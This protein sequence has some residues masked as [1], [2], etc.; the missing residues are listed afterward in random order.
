[1]SINRSLNFLRLSFVLSTILYTSLLAAQVPAGFAQKHASEAVIEDINILER[2]LYQIHG[3]IFTYH[4]QAAFKD[5]FGGLRA[6][7]TEAMTTLE[8]YKVIG[9]LSTLIGDSHTE[10]NLPEAYQDYVDSEMLLFPFGVRYLGEKLYLTVNLSGSNAFIPGAEILS[11]NGRDALEIFKVL[12]QYFERDGFN[13]SGPNRQASSLFMDKYGLIIGQPAEFTLEMIS[14]DGQKYTAKVAS[15]TWPILEE[16]LEAHFAAKIPN[17]GPKPPL[18]LQIEGNTAYLRVRSFS[19][20]RIKRGKQ[21]F[22]SFF[23]DAFE[24][25][26][27]AGVENLILDVRNNGGGSETVFMR[28]LNHLL[29][30]PYLVYREL[31]TATTTIPDHHLYPRDKPAR[32]EKFATRKLTP[33]NGRYLDLKDP[34]AN[35]ASPKSPHFAGKVYVLINEFSYSATGDFCGVLQQY[36]RATFVGAETGGNPYV[37]TAGMDLT[38]ILPNTKIEVRIPLLLFII[39][40]DRANTGHG[41]QPDIPVSL[42][43]EDVLNYQDPVLPYVRELIAKEN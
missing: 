5:Y 18:E 31:S 36:N 26:A 35:I 43:I 21:H 30:E 14:P 11:I 10:I 41:M 28:I 6:Q 39:N 38:L 37:N 1:M 19:P 4:D 34:S 12:R 27:A 24:Q 15:Q 23:K 3:G 42:S 13:L 2:H 16:R 17:S 7:V 32:L 8:A 33:R 25:I 40:N 22:K 29:D 9:P 20:D